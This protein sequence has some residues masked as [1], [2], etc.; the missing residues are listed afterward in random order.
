VTK[1]LMAVYW[2][3]RFA[4]GFAFDPASESPM[5]EPLPLLLRA[6]RRE[7]VERAASDG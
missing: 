5:A 1:P 2:S 3:G 7:Q 6:A 4:P